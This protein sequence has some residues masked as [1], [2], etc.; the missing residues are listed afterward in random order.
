MAGAT[1]V[2]AGLAP[3]V[4]WV[5]GPDAAY[6]ATPARA[7]EILAGATLACLGFEG[8]LPPVPRWL[9]PLCLTT[10]VLGAATLPV[11]GGLAYRG[12]LPLVAAVSTG[13]IYG[14][15]SAGWVRSVLSTSPL[16]G[17]GRISYGVYL[18]HWPVYVWLDEPATGRSGVM[19]LGRL[20]RGRSKEVKRAVGH[21]FGWD[22][23]FAAG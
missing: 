4:A 6:W 8:H 5:W 15:Q 16:V 12:G 7:S 19:L 17:L 20:A 13:L 23:L 10:L 22:E 2:A 21:A 14:L 1:L 11:Q 3:A 18:Y 9:A